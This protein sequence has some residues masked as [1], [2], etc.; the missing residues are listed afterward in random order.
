MA[1]KF[2][3]RIGHRF[4]QVDDVPDD[5][6]MPVMYGV[7]DNLFD[8]GFSVIPNIVL[9]LVIDGR[10]EYRVATARERVAAEALIRSKSEAPVL[11]VRARPLRND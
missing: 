3:S 4:F 1:S 11:P 6:D 7:P 8:G 9:V 10:Q 2:Q 5:L